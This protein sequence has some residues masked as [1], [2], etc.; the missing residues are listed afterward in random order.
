MQSETKRPQVIH[1][2]LAKR[3]VSHALALLAMPLRLFNSL[4]P[5]PAE[6]SKSVVMIEPFG[7]GDAISHEPLARALRESGWNVTLC[8]RPE[9]R[10]LF[11]GLAWVNSEAPW[12]R[13][14]RAQKYVIREYFGPALRAFLQAL[15]GAGRGAVGL[16]TRGD[17]RSVLLLHLA[18][19]RRVITIS[20]YAGSN[21]RILPGAAERVKFSPDLRR[22]EMNLRCAEP[23][24]LNVSRVAP[25]S[26]PHL[27][28]SAAPSR[29]VGLVPIAPWEGKWW[30][31][32]K[33]SQ[34]VAQL[35]V[36]GVEA[37]GLCGPGQ[38]DLARRELGG[39]TQVIECSTVEDWAQRLQEFAAVVTLDSGPMHLA[40]ALGVPVMALFGQG[41][42]PLWAPSGP[43]S[44]V[45]TH[46]GDPD[47]RLAMPTEENTESGREFMR[48]IS[49]EE[50][51]A[52]LDGA[53]QRQ[54]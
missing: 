32:E 40:D 44:A 14:A 20:S 9:W 35:K 42:L 26:F 34:L 27:R 51:L 23:L 3:L 7:L 50:V 37:V 49:V 13:H 5:V 36:R 38:G 24:G 2:R 47:F 28:N 18:G 29:R 4:R 16:D 33:W 31:C 54:V 21:L 25:P 53:V 41:S 10:V 17:I 22:W 1:I 15:R 8:A 11:P 52:A 39:D 43:A 46:Q 45:I 19:C 48:R 6:R 12:G 30:Q